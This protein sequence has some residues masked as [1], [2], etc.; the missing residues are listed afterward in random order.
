MGLPQKQ[1]S[2]IE[3]RMAEAE[4]RQQVRAAYA[5]FIEHLGRTHFVSPD[6]AARWE[7]EGGAVAPE[8]QALPHASVRFCGPRWQ[9]INPVIKAAGQ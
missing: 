7:D 6:E 9:S 2:R 5:K 4:R 1:P 3:A 8:R